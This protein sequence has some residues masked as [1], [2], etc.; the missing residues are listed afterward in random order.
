MTFPVYK[1]FEAAAGYSY[2]QILHCP[3]NDH[4]LTFE[5]KFDEDIR[6]FDSLYSNL[7]FEVK[8]QIAS[9]IQSKHGKLDLKIEKTQQQTNSVDCGIYAIAFATDLSYGYDPASLLYV[10]G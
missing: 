8:K 1:C 6:V 3:A 5:V 9:I 7:S 2:I 4:W 10:D